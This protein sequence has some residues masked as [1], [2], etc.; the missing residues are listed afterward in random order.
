MTHYPPKIVAPPLIRVEKKFLQN[1][2]SK[3]AE[4]CADFKNAEKSRVWQKGKIFF[5]KNLIFSNLENSEKKSLG[6]S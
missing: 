1:L 2:A 6:I 3:K 4:F 5:R